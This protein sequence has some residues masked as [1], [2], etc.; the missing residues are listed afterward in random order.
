MLTRLQ[1]KGFKNLVDIDVRFGAF[2]C[3]AGANGVGKSNL[4]DAILFLGELT[5]KSLLEAVTGVRGEG[6]SADALRVF[7]RWAGGSA[8]EMSFVADMLVDPRA[9]D[10]LGQEAKASVTFLRYS[11]TIKATHPVGAP[12]PQLEVAREELDY[13]KKGELRDEL[14][15]AH[16]K[17]AWFDSVF[18]GG[19]RSKYISTEEREG[20]TFIRVHEDSGHQGRARQVKGAGLRRTLLSTLNTAETPTAL[21]ARREMQSWKL[22]Q[23]EPAHLRM[24][25]ELKA[26][27]RLE[28]D[29]RG[30]AA[31]LNRLLRAPKADEA[32]RAQL[33]NRLHGLI[34]DI[35]DVWIDVDEKREL[36]TLLARSR[37][38]VD[39][40]ARDLSDGTLRFLALAVLEQDPSWTGLLCMEE[41]E[42]GIHPSRVP[43]ILDLLQGLAVDLR[44]ASGPDNPLRQVIVN[45]HSPV[46]VGL[47][48]ED[49]IIFAESS[50]TGAHGRDQRMLRL[51][52]LQGTWRAQGDQQP[53]VPVGKVLE[54]LNA[55]PAALRAQDERGA[56]RAESQSGSRSVGARDDVRQL[57]FPGI[58]GPST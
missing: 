40:R 21:V 27:A 50:P 2:T 12:I 7:S 19:R 42:N 47:A 31:T 58:L 11:L 45:T 1:V 17:K 5:E 44:E 52:P 10:D 37:D 35:A 9:E 41:P 20:S 43:A 6:R 23:L 3:I 24:P 55:L 13:I 15:F 28:S 16:G 57:L 49:S 54:L 39:F 36:L 4:F 33:A 30:L 34:D 32:T 18:Q 29:G 53:A 51:L 38:G 46:V 25:D 8:T 22:L 26:P 14:P 56:G 48:P